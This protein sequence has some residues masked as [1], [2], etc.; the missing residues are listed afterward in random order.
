MTPFDTITNVT[1]SS[2]DV[3]A[4]WKSP[5]NKTTCGL[6]WEHPAVADVPS[7]STSFLP[8]PYHFEYITPNDSKPG[9]WA[10]AKKSGA[11]RMTNYKH[12]STHVEDFIGQIPQRSYYNR[13][14]WC[15]NQTPPW[16]FNPR[17]A[18]L[19]S[20]WTRQGSFL[21][22][23]AL[24]PDAPYYEA[25]PLSNLS[26]EK[27]TVRTR[28]V[29]SLTRGYDF[30]AELGE[31][32]ETL[33][34]ARNLLSIVRNP[35]KSWMDLE[36]KIRKRNW[37]G[38]TKGL[39][40]ALMNAWMQYRYAI[41]PV[42][43]SAS[44]IYKLMQERGYSYKTERA[45][46]VVPENNPP[47]NLLRPDVYFYDV[48]EVYSVEVRAIGKVR[49]SSENQRL[50]DQISLNPI[51]T[52][53]EV[54]KLSF[55]VDWFVNFGDWLIAQTS[56]LT[57]FYEERC[58]ASIVRDYRVFSTYLHFEHDYSGTYS[59]GPI[60]LAGG[61]TSS[62]LEW[63]FGEVVT[64]DTLLRRTVVNN[65]TRELFQPGDTKLTINPSMTWKRWIDAYVLSIRPLSKALRS[66]K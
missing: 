10:K 58:F 16:G 60:K 55:V 34:Y 53:W 20:S 48:S 25:L 9:D 61:I 62:K 21:D 15:D 54:T 45:K 5:D 57:A 14:G 66:L 8:D 13:G 44:D 46:A 37:K 6:T 4:N 18:A 12:L 43:Y 51:T 22:F 32:K 29:S 50:L 28:V 41:M 52:A 40:E 59:R 64:A 27:E 24:F 3:F 36:A 39:H 30:G 17:G 11:I 2:Q 63:D 23:R 33:L 65:Y 56:Q 19:S 31:L 49:Y 47:T 7:S 38:N 1:K 26:K 42:Y 35:L